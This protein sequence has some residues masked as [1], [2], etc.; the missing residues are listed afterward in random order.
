MQGNDLEAFYRFA[1]RIRCRHQCLR[2]SVTGCFTQALLTIR[3]RP[4]F[5]GQA[6]F[7]EADQLLRNGP[8][9]ESWNTAPATWADLRRFR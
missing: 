1:R 8:V 4:D 7:T 6:H 9:A 2:K 3:D 5:S